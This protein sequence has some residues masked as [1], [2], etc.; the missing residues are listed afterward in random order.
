MC[1]NPNHRTVIGLWQGQVQFHKFGEE[2]ESSVHS[3]QP[4]LTQYAVAGALPEM[5][6]DNANIVV[7]DDAVALM[8]CNYFSQLNSDTS[9][10]VDQRAEVTQ[11]LK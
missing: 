11:K 6:D 3:I 10:I 7:S 5:K 9:G 8:V 2:R 1:V 4:Y